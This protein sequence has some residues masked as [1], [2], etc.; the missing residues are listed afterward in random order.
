VGAVSIPPGQAGEARRI[1]GEIA[2][3]LRAEGTT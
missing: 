3:A 1:A 2:A